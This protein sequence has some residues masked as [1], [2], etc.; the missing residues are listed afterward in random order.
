MSFRKA[1]PH[2]NREIL[3]S[4]DSKINVLGNL[5]YKPTMTI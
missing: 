5:E 3:I 1:T 2:N 4:E